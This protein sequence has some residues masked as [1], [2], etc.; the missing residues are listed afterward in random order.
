MKKNIYYISILLFFLFSGCKK[1]EII[2][3]KPGESISP[4]TNLQ[5]SI[6]G[7]KVNLNWKLPS[8]LPKDIVTPVSVLIL[9]SIDGINKGTLVLENAPENYIYTSF[10]PSKKYKFTIKVIGSVNTEDPFVSNLRY[11][12]GETVAVN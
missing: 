5:G 12:P 6:A 7:N 1:D 4:V 10:D 2:S 11:S 8:S 3:S 9:T